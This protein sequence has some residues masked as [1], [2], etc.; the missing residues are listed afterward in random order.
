MKQRVI[1]FKALR[2]DGQGWVPGDLIQEQISEKCFIHYEYHSPPTMSDPGGCDID[3]LH[4]VKPETI[5]QYCEHRDI[6][7]KELFQGDV[8]KATFPLGWYD[9][10]FTFDEDAVRELE[11]TW[12]GGWFLTDPFDDEISI[13]MESLDTM[14]VKLEFIKNIH[15]K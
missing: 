9:D 12:S 11:I 5:C 7:H 8:V 14:D 10:N 4:E 6:K 2:F 3:R 13:F 15:D 1:L